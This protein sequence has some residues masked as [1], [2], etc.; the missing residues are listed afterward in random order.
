MSGLEAKLKEHGFASIQEA[1]GCRAG[2]IGEEL[3]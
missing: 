2:Q 3:N 1:V